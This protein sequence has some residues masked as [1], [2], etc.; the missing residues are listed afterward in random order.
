MS[1]VMC[2]GIL[3]CSKCCTYP[4]RVGVYEC[5]VIS[6]SVDNLL[7]SDHR[8]VFGSFV[9]GITSQFV[10]NR[11]SLQE[12]AIITL[13]FDTV[14][15][16]VSFFYFLSIHAIIICCLNFSQIPFRCVGLFILFIQTYSLLF[17]FYCVT[18]LFFF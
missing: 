11:T 16:Q 12:D 7:N 13:I 18:S 6:G 5:F 10:Q 9:L 2:Q 17:F 8:P 15:A 1:R 4:C 14:E 3:I